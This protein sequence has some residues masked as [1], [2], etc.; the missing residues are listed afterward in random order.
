LSGLAWPPEQTFEALGAHREAREVHSIALKELDCVAILLREVANKADIAWHLYRV[1]D[2]EA[3]EAEASRALLEAERMVLK[4]RPTSVAGCDA[5]L[6]FLQSYLGD[7]PEIGLVI[8]AIG[9]VAAAVKM[10]ATP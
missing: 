8:E 2:L 7:D 9:H 1:S 5:L 6:G 3:A 10:C 4:T